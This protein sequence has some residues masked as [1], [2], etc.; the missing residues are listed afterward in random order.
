MILSAQWLKMLLP[1][2]LL[3][4]RELVEN[5]SLYE[6]DKRQSA[7]WNHEGELSTKDGK[8]ENVK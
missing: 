6:N 4:F 5:V 7:W 2:D 8:W 1:V 3:M